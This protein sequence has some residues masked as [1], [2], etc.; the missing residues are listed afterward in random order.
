[1]KKFNWKQMLLLIVALPVI[2]VIARNMGSM[3]ADSRNE[4]DY[5]QTESGIGAGEVVTVASVQDAEGA[6]QADLNMDM[7]HFLEQYTVKRAVANA[8]KHFEAM[9]YDGK[10]SMESNALYV[11][12]GSMK[13]AVIRMW[14][15]IESVEMGAV[16]VIGIQG[17]DLKRVLCL[18][19]SR[20]QIPISYGVCGEKIRQVFGQ[21]I[22]R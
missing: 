16:S 20:E 8:Q 19:E 4:R 6:T 9:G 5:R 22:G 7:L 15:S 2:S 12:S 17:T 3:L 18:S 11:D 14:P 1:M 10:I 21:G 13:F